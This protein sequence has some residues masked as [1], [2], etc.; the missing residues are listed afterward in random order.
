MEISGSIISIK[1]AR[2]EID[3]VNEAKEKRNRSRFSK[4]KD[5]FFRHDYS[6]DQDGYPQ[7]RRQSYNHSDYNRHQDP[8]QYPCRLIPLFEY[9]KSLFK[10]IFQL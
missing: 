4:N 1:P 3:Q 6:K 9:F 2:K 8:Q 7:R 5:D 10:L